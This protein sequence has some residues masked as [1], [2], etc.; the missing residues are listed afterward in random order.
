MAGGDGS[1][2]WRFL[3]IN[4][5]GGGAWTPP[6]HVLRGAELLRASHWNR[7]DVHPSQGTR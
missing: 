6:M 1:P 2:Q 7:P 5:D 3:C 4:D